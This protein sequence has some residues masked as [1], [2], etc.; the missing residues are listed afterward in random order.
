ML[1]DRLNRNLVAQATRDPLTG[2][3]NRR[4]FEEIAFREISGAARTGMSLSLLMFDLDQ[5]KQINDRYGHAAGDAVLNTVVATLRNCL[6]DEDFLCRW[7]GDEFFAL[8]PRAKREQAQ[9]VAE[10]VLTSFEALNFSIEEQPIEIAV[11]IGIVT[12]EGSSKDI[13]SLVL[14]ADAALY[15][16]KEAGRKR[17]AFARVGNAVN[18]S[19]QPGTPDCPSRA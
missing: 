3:F 7:G 6:R 15:Q 8:L 17:F 10:R 2:L 4:A 19:R 1:S 12:H 16:A 9:N 11:S 14:L 13:A 18:G 5:F